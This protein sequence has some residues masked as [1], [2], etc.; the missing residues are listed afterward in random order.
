M[1]AYFRISNGERYSN[2]YQ[3]QFSP[4]EVPPE[5]EKKGLLVIVLLLMHLI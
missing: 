5:K 4:E 3:E 2:L 1:Q